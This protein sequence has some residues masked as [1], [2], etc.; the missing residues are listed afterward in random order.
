MLEFYP[1]W[2]DWYLSA[3]SKATL[4]DV[5]IKLRSVKSKTII[6]TQRTEYRQSTHVI[7]ELKT[8]SL[9]SPGEYEIVMNY[10]GEQIVIGEFL[11]G[12]FVDTLQPRLVRRPMAY[13]KYDYAQWI[14]HTKLSLCE[15]SDTET[16]DS[17]FGYPIITITNIEIADDRTPKHL[18]RLA[19]WL[20]SAQGVIDYTQAPTLYALSPGDPF[21]FPR[22]PSELNLDM[23]VLWQGT[24][25]AR[26]AAAGLDPV[27]LRIGIRPMD[28]AGNL[29]PALESVILP[30]EQQPRPAEPS[31]SPMLLSISKQP[32]YTR[33]SLTTL[34]P[35]ILAIKRSVF[36]SRWKLAYEQCMFAWSV[37]GLMPNLCRSVP[38]QAGLMFNSLMP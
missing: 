4:N 18:M 2:Q 1:H 21:V 9:L 10:K 13:Y 25:C 28:I 32:K 31:K 20:Q 17:E 7:I 8:S 12:H 23:R 37:A 36:A 3:N 14:K 35:F 22:L 11:V 34:G 5:D 15:L 33:G 24:S 29:G 6:D 16:E 27:K 19:V 38:A 30:S 26:F